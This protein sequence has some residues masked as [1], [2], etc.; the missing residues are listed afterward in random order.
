LS[1]AS[2]PDVQRLK[3]LLKGR[4]FSRGRFA[5]CVYLSLKPSQH[6]LCG[7]RPHTDVPVLSA[8]TQTIA[9]C[10]ALWAATMIHFQ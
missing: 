10:N 9:P 1:N 7:A 5:A 8:S 4:S 3:S 6:L 2:E